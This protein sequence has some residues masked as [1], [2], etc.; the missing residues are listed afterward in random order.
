[1]FDPSLFLSLSLFLSFTRVFF[2]FSLLIY[3]MYL[4]YVRVYSIFWASVNVVAQNFFR[5]HA[6]CIYFFVCT[7]SDYLI[8]DFEKS[9]PTIFFR[10]FSY[11]CTLYIFSLFS[12][13]FIVK[14]DGTQIASDVAHTLFG[15]KLCGRICIISL[16]LLLCFWGFR[17]SNRTELKPR[18]LLSSRKLE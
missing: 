15:L 8:S 2:Q 1:M 10:S 13:V 4:Y 3:R 9:L 18:C 7:Y 12:F 5:E 6:N 14:S 16:G 11:L 17:L